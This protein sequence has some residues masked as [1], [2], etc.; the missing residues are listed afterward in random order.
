MSKMSQG[1]NERNCRENDE[2]ENDS[3]TGT[4][5]EVELVASLSFM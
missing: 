2:D 5:I 3:I 4:V 1:R